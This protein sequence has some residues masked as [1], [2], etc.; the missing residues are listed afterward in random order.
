ML[1][2]KTPPTDRHAENETRTTFKLL[3]A[4]TTIMASAQA[5]EE[6]L[7]QSVLAS[8][9]PDWAQDA[10]NTNAASHTANRDIAVLNTRRTRSS[11]EQ[12][13]E[14]EDRDASGE[15]VEE[16]AEG[17]DDIDLLQA[18]ENPVDAQVDEE[19]EVEEDEDEDAEGEEEIVEEEE[20]A[21]MIEGE[22]D[23]E[24]AEAEVEDADGE[25]DDEVEGVGAV[26]IMPPESELGEGDESEAS[27]LAS[28]AE[29][30]VEED[31]D[32]DEEVAWEDARDEAEEDEESE[33]AATNTCIFCKQTEENDPSE[34][35][36]TYLACKSCGENGRC[37]LATEK[38]QDS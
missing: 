24:D 10:S 37:C 8:E 19:G 12:Q 30:A 35:F 3:E 29:E 27:D 22:E 21:G 17:E 16:D 15:D 14:E 36:E 13:V 33:V 4:I 38:E 20:E 34:D 5:M 1:P 31:S 7:Q 2:F 25:D 11:R 18:A 28:G 23:E 9:T 6:E 26:K 32:A